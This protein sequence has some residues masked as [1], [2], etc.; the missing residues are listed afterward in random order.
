MCAVFQAWR[1]YLIREEIRARCQA[2]AV[3]TSALPLLRSLVLRRHQQRKDAALAVAVTPIQAVLRGWLARRSFSQQ[4]SSIICIQSCIRGW[5]ARKA[6]GPQV[7]RRRYLSKD[8]ACVELSKATAGLVTECT[9]YPPLLLLCTCLQVREMAAR[10]H[11]IELQPS[12]HKK[13]LGPRVKAAL[14][15][16]LSCHSVEQARSACEA[17]AWGTTYSRNA[18]IWL[19]EDGAVSALDKF[20]RVCSTNK[21]N[22]SLIC[23]MLTT[24]ANILSHS[25]RAVHV[26][27]TLLAGMMPTISDLLQLFRCVVVLYH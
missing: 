11:C 26:D 18:C 23:S 10:L 9:G 1:V 2:L 13:C 5:L 6:A 20:M 21:S 22:A 14:S 7:C 25:D 16:L 17:A 8:S 3:I 27:P 24:L 15:Q 19:V 4:L 12:D